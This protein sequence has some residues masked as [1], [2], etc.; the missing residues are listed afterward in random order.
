M[1]G[2]GRTIG[3]IGG[4]VLGSFFGPAGTLLGAAGGGM[5]GGMF[6]D[7]E[8]PARPTGRIAPD[9]PRYGGLGAGGE[10]ERASQLGAQNAAQTREMGQRLGAEAQWGRTNATI[11]EANAN[12]RAAGLYGDA[13]GMYSRAEGNAAD[14]A[15]ARG[16]AMAGI[17]R[18]R[19]FYEQGPGPS[20][21][22]AQ[23]RAGQ[24]S[25]NRN[26]LALA[27]TGAGGANSMRAAMR[28][29][30]AGNQQANQAA[31]TL[32]AQ[33]AA[34]WRQA[35]LGAMGAEQSALQNVRAGDVGV[36][37]QRFGAA[38]QQLGAAGQA[39]QQA[40]G[41]GGLGAQYAALNNQA[42]L[43]SEGMAIGQNQFGEQQR[44]GILGNQLSADTS[45]Y[46]ADR[47]VAVGMA[48]V[49]Q[50]D[51]AADMAMTGSLIGSGVQ[52]MSDV[53]AKENIQPASAVAR[54]EAL[55]SMAGQP[56]ATSQ[57][58]VDLRP[59]KGY[60]YDYK[61]PTMGPDDQVGPMAQDLEKTAAAP[62]VS[63]GPDGM[64]RVDPNRLTM[65]NT[66]AIGEQQRRLDELEAMVNGGG[67]SETTQLDAAG[68]KAFQQWAKKNGIRDVDHPDSHYDYRGA[69][70][71]GVKAGPD[72][73]WPDTFKQHGHPTFSV[74]S[75][76]SHGAN[77]GGH[78]EGDRYVPAMA[79]QHPRSQRIR[80]ERY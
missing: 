23:L 52:M 44:S 54:L 71:A 41:Y 32:R 63:T 8:S 12:R 13:A 57:P 20:A 25:A 39:G 30:A 37:G 65:T 64:K 66:A 14:A 27:R 70:K 60:S 29:G 24:D 62:A 69:F 15:A 43:G 51:R 18:L 67:K 31:A 5:I 6:D 33:E 2:T 36:M 4:G 11:D 68:E 73:H 74:E 42:R 28:A 47:G 22:Q 59:A 75:Q 45:R 19:S 76:Y 3:T 40:L 35:Q 1:P 16:D 7:D 77:D 78:W 56:Q 80:V 49:A 53:R 9:A 17:G 34:N 55:Q 38:G 72:A 10:A 58:A 48:N 50:R 61:N 21:A 46:G 79:G 26:A